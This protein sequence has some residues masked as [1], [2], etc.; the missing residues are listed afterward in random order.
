[1]VSSFL[2]ALCL[3]IG[4]V[5]GSG[6]Q[7]ASAPSGDPLQQHYEAAAKFLQAGDQGRAAA[8]YQAFLALAL[9]RIANGKA[10]A[11]QFDAADPLFREAIS[12]SPGDLDLQFDYANACF[13][14]DKLLQAKSLAQTVAN[15]PGATRAARLLLGRVLFHLGEFE[16]AR[17]QLEP[18]FAEKPE[19]NVGYLLTKIY[20]LLHQEQAARDLIQGMAENFGDTAQNRIFFGRAYSE[21]DHSEEA[22][23]EFHQAL[24]QDSRA[25]DAHYYLGLTYL[26]HN[27][28]AGYAQAVPE[29]RAEL[30]INPNDFRS[31]YMLGYI[32]LKQRNFSEAE[33]E[34][35][36]ALASA[37][38]DLQSLLQLAEVYT[39]T[40]RLP[41]A[42]KTLRNAISIA[43][44]N[45]ESEGQAGRAHYLL[46]RILEKTG[47]A[48]EAAQ[49]MKIVA[50]IQK[51]LGPSSMQTADEN[52]GEKK[53]KEAQDAPKQGGVSPEK[54][55]QLSQF[56]DRLKP[57]VADAYNSL[58]AIASGERDFA[59]AVKYFQQARAWDASLPG[60]DRN[61]GAALFYSGEYVD[62]V[63]PL[64]RHLQTQPDD[65]PG[66]SMLALSLY[67]TGDFRGVIEALQ[68]VS[69]QITPDRN[70]Y[71][72]YADSYY[73]LGKFQLDAGQTD[74]AVTSLE[75]AEK[76]SPQNP[77]VHVQLA[78]AYRR[79]G[80]EAD[81]KK[82]E[83][84]QSGPSQ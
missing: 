83:T 21:T 29:F 12:F 66:R 46:G 62:A 80:R 19:F 17:Q 4:M 54:L 69:S 38:H 65:L 16:P 20:L 42:E 5:P 84:I 68:P 82:E 63:Q 18:V 67:Q 71:F 43:A 53:T 78:L 11:G 1:V 15:S 49:E 10:D 61:L 22:I 52:A 36:S 47:R 24:A 40:S 73:Q 32:A 56:I 27:E 75:A 81:A 59:T 2:L 79:A 31:H 50:D 39:D 30:Q 41:E 58:G 72:A 48:Q 44:N 26:G 3:L 77:A 34:L 64:R 57:G 37:P 33:S 55:A 74:A 70:L 13:D 9:H 51:R 7:T 76:L 60:L 35:L 45:P 25:P 14:A 8:E 28:S 6:A 23:A